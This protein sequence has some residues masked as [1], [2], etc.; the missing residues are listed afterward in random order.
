[1]FILPELEPGTPASSRKRRYRAA[2]RRH[3]IAV[4]GERDPFDAATIA[5]AAALRARVGEVLELLD[6]HPADPRPIAAFA[7]TATEPPLVPALDE[8]VVR[9]HT[10][11]FPVATGTETVTWRPWSGDGSIADFTAS[12]GRG[13]G[14][15][16]DTGDDDLGATALARAKAVFAPATLVDR[17]GTRLGHGGG[18]YDRALAHLREAPVIAVVHP[19]ELLAAGTLPR[20]EHDLPVDAVVTA[21]G[22]TDLR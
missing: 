17:S 3:R 16:P 13:F 6:V 14:A 22:V 21:E 9:G 12:A 2:L 10:L 7:P 19:D 4:Y 15:E 8:L 20:E 18:Y 1:M 11:I 5:E